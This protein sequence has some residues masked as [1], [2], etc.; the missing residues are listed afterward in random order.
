MSQAKE[1]SNGPALRDLRAIGYRLEAAMVDGV[2]D[3]FVFQA[4]KGARLRVKIQKRNGAERAAGQHRCGV[5]YHDFGNVDSFV[6]W[7][8]GLGRLLVV[9]CSRLS[10]IYTENAQTNRYTRPRNHQWEVIFRFTHDRAFIGPIGSKKWID[11]TECSEPTPQP[12]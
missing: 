7:I 6:F 11:I 1:T 10:S 12:V 3:G 2:R 4:P 9:P 5:C 8:R